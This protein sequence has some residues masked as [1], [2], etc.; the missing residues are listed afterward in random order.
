MEWGSM[1]VGG[2]EGEW[3]ADAHALHEQFCSF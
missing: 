2:R 1:G 3:T